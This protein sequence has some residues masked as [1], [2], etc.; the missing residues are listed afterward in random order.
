MI[1]CDTKTKRFINPITQKMRSLA[2][3]QPASKSLPNPSWMASVCWL[4]G[5]DDRHVLISLVIRFCDS[6][7]ECF[8]SRMLKLRRHNRPVSHGVVMSVRRSL[9]FWL[10]ERWY[11][12][13]VSSHAEEGTMDLYELGKVG[14]IFKVSAHANGYDRTQRAQCSFA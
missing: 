13:C 6:W 9:F 1:R 4:H 3:K 11:L 10:L 5:R 2:R 12:Q 7:D 14:Q 8:A